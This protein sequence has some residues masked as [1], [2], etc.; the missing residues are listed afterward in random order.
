MPIRPFA[1]L[2]AFSADEIYDKYMRDNAISHPRSKNSE[3]FAVWIYAKI[4]SCGP[5]LPSSVSRY[6]HTTYILDANKAHKTVYIL[7]VSVHI[8]STMQ[9]TP[10]DFMDSVKCWGN[11]ITERKHSYIQKLSLHTRL[12]TLYSKTPSCC[13][14][15][16][17]ILV[18]AWSK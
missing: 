3:T 14:A 15:S 18:L 12:F 11:L 1:A 4:T 10:F 2:Y 7:S 9:F 17:T 5:L 13:T 6:P 16:I 8:F